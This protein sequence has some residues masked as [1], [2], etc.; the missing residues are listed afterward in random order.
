MW[1][2]TDGAARTAL[3][4]GVYKTRFLFHFPHLCYSIH[5][6]RIKI[7]FEFSIGMEPW[8]KKSGFREWLYVYSSYVRGVL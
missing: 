1:V 8:P 2:D 6:D 7:G 4:Y 5:G 3:Q